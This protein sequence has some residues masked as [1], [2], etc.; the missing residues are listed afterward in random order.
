[1]N[2]IQI[3]HRILLFFCIVAI[4]LL[5]SIHEPHAANWLPES[6]PTLD[7][8]ANEL[9]NNTLNDDASTG[10][11]DQALKSPMEFSFSGYTKF[12]QMINT[13]SD[14]EFSDAFKKNELRNS[15]KLKYGT[16]PFYLY[17][18][19]NQYVLLSLSDYDCSY[20]EDSGFTR[21]LGYTSSHAEISFS[22]LYVNYTFGTCQLRAGNQ[23]LAWGSVDMLNPTSYFN[24]MDFRELMF[25]DDDELLLGVPLVTGTFFM[26]S[27][28]LETVL[29]PV[30]APAPLAP[31]GSFWAVQKNNLLYTAYVEEPEALETSLEN[32]GL[33]A[34][35]SWQAF[36]GDISVSAY[37]GPDKD[38]SY[39][40]DSIDITPN[41]PFV[42]HVIPRYSLLNIVGFDFSRLMGK[43][44]VHLEAAYSPNKT[45]TIA[46]DV[47]LDQIQIPYKVKESPYLSFSTGF[48]YFLPLYKL[49]KGHKGESVFTFFWNHSSY[50][51]KEVSES[52]FSDV[53][54]FR[55]DDHFLRNRLG[56]ALEAI[57]DIKG[58]GSII[59]PKFTW[60]LTEKLTAGISY[61]NISGAPSDNGQI[62]P[63][64]FY[65]KD[66]DIVMLEMQYDY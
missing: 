54:V 44:V 16:D 61:G 33:C 15:F 60:Q 58:G 50:F 49:I 53:M 34:K 6:M 48:N 36:S 39:I 24:P 3:P 4:S 22:E 64:F 25:K 65:F 41:E 12:E 47:P 42:V 19:S 43:A 32:M 18:V 55:Y 8:P 66:K 28:T 29:M 59:W 1:M 31:K 35:I 38:A 17:T 27:Y 46:Q 5:A 2:L 11:P 56:V 45:S 13:D 51:D 40:P 20:S 57:L 23:I 26:E 9:T 21:S 7:M 30:H 52:L 62:D 37:R 14:Q 63:M 10:F